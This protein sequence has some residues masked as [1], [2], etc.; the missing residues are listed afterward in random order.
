MEYKINQF[1]LTDIKYK[2]LKGLISCFESTIPLS[3]ISLCNF[4]PN[5]IHFK[6]SENKFPKTKEDKKILKSQAELILSSLNSKEKN[7]ETNF[8]FSMSNNINKI[9]LK[10]FLY[11]LNISLLSRGKNKDSDLNDD[12]I[13]EYK[14][15]IKE[16]MNF[17][18]LISY[19]TCFKDEYG[20]EIP[21]TDYCL[22][23]YV[24]K[25]IQYNKL[26]LIQFNYEYLTQNIIYQSNN[27]TIDNDNSNRKNNIHIF[28]M[29][30]YNLP[31]NELSNYLYCEETKDYFSVFSEEETL[32]DITK[33]FLF[34]NQFRLL[35]NTAPFKI[36]TINN[37][38][39]NK[40]ENLGY[41]LNAIKNEYKYYSILFNE[42]LRIKENFLISD[43]DERK[44]FGSIFAILL[45]SEFDFIND[46]LIINKNYRDLKYNDEK[47]LTN[48]FSQLRNILIN[49][50]RFSFL[51]TNSNQIDRKRYPYL[52]SKISYCLGIPEDKIIYILLSE[53]I[54]NKENNKNKNENIYRENIVSNEISLFKNILYF[55]KLLYLKSIDN[56]L[57]IFSLYNKRKKLT[58]SNSSYKPK[59]L[60]NILLMRSNLIYN[61]TYEKFCGFKFFYN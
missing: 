52:L 3:N 38:E 45:L 2:D 56:I 24:D 59:K 54:Y 15:D 42:Y 60:L 6:C 41:N 18:N 34:I 11:Q 23:I 14:Q 35:K 47:S 44:I 49:D 53:T 36:M 13:K 8:C 10:R 40:D 12:N 26:N 32:D 20:D 4:G 28:Y 51:N 17:Y 9:Y 30:I 19:F 33:K 61:L 58:F 5:L 43:E 55:I 48:I 7:D 37:E 1:N 16:I 27:N 39:E 50:T 31:L 21:I 22:S 57:E 25:N 29:L 46:D